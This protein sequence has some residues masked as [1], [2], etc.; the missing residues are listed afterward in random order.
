MD[1]S[2]WFSPLSSNHDMTAFRPLTLVPI[3]R[4]LGV[5]L[6]NEIGDLMAQSQHVNSQT[7]YCASSDNDWDFR[8]KSAFDRISP[9]QNNGIVA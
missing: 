3:E 7:F 9:S 1:V 6:A 8:R 5:L 4:V 2:L